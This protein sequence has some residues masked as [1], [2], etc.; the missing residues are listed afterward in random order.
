MMMTMMMMMMM[1]DDD[2]DDDDEGSLGSLSH[3]YGCAHSYVFG[4]NSRACNWSHK[5][6]TKFTLF[7]E[8]LEKFTLFHG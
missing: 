2:D 1:D 7:L 5:R 8:R 6:K 4:C 3:A